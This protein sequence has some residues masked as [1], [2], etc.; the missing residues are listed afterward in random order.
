VIII[1]R[2]T[3]REKRES[4]PNIMVGWL[5]T[6]KRLMAIFP[7]YHGRQSGKLKQTTGYYPRYYGTLLNYYEELEGFP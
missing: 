7:Y 3:V 2:R 5:G 1:L 6:C 4:V